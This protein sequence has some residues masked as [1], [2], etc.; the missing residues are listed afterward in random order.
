MNRFLKHAEV[1]VDFIVPVAIFLLLISVLGELLFVTFFDKHHLLFEIIE[2]VV[3]GI[4][5]LDLLFKYRRASNLKLF[6][7]NYWIE[8]L[9]IFPFFLLFRLF[10]GFLGILGILQRVV[11]EVQ[12]LVHGGLET[13]RAFSRITAELRALTG[14]EAEGAQIV[15]E[16]E[17][18]GK[19]SRS[20]RLARI[21]RPLL[22]SLRFVKIGSGDFKKRLR[23][24]ERFVV[25]FLHRVFVAF[26]F[27][28]RPVVKPKH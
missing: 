16:V 18:A 27:Y 23:K 10:E 2:Y 1:L 17:A 3:I 25:H 19:I 11:P 28:E 22:R 4:F 6:W 14:L 24:D 15:K 26:A 9:A 8:I 5:V 20:S 7:K 13:Q 21:I 12:D